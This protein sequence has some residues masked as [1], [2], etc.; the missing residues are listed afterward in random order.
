MK[1]FCAFAVFNKPV[2]LFWEI[3][4]IEY[5]TFLQ[6]LHH[7]RLSWLLPSMFVSILY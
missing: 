1:M 3:P 6:I 4:S 7:I 5:F 2:Q